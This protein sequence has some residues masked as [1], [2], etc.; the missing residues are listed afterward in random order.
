MNRI[1]ISLIVMMVALA[2]A[3]QARA[4]FNYGIKAG[5]NVDKM[6]ISGTDFFDTHN[7]CGFTAGV[8]G[9]YIAPAIG[10]GVDVSLMFSRLYANVEAVYG[11]GGHVIR[12]GETVH[13]SFFEI[14]L[15]VKYKFNIPAINKIIRPYVFTGPSV[16][17]KLG[18]SESFMDTKKTQWGW[19]LGLGVELIKHL[20]VGA[21]YT[22]G[23]NKL[24]SMYE[25]DIFTTTKEIKVRNNYWTVTLA[26]MF[27]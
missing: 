11:Q 19:D 23:I 1:K 21:G 24:A 10:L 15:H 12:A 26:W 7:R 8:T 13:G 18:K 9:E 2:G 4:D 17:F 5:L 3:L 14:P 22:F 16:A 6:H 27:K 20:Q 25:Q